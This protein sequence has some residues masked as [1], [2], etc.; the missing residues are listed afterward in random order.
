MYSFSRLLDEKNE[1]MGVQ[2]ATQF[3]IR[4]GQSWKTTFF[5]IWGGQALSI[6]GS[7]LVQFALIWYLTVT[8]GSATVLAT[9]SLVGDA[10]RC[11]PRPICRHSGRPLESPPHHVAGRQH[12]R[13]GYHLP[14]RFVCP[15][16]CGDLAYLCGDVHPLLAGSFHGNAMTA[17][18]SLMVPVENLTR[19]Q[20]INQMLNGGLNVVSAPLGALFCWW[21][22]C[23]DLH[24]Y[25]HP[26]VDCLC[27]VLTVGG[28][29]P[30]HRGG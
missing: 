13:S 2:L 24:S 14:G 3:S 9:A 19:I 6:L 15:G 25:P 1:I 8:T 18:T 21:S 28:A 30:G 4:D 20:G 16:C 7:Q 11:N 12:H 29:H 27:A 5:T 17:S 23:N 22:K 10:A 26:V